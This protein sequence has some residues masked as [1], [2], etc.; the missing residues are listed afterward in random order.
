M[1]LKLNHD[2]LFIQQMMNTDEYKIYNFKILWVYNSDE[3]LWDSLE[4]KVK[5]YSSNIG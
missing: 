5:I 1:S 4:C 2:W 3:Y